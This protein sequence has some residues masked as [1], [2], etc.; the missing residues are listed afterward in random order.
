MCEPRRIEPRRPLIDPAVV[1]GRLTH[2]APFAQGHGAQG[3]FLGLGLLYYTLAYAQRAQV[4]VC[5]G[6]GGGFVPRLMRTAQ[7][8]LALPG[9]RTILVD[10][11]LPEAGFGAPEWLDESCFFRQAFPD[12]EIVLRT[13]ADAAASV[14]TPAGL[15]IDY[16][17][18]DADHSYDGARADFR[19]YLPLLAP[20]GIVTLH[21][22]SQPGCGVHRLIDD[23]RA[24]PR[25]DVLDFPEHGAG[26]ALV[27][28][29]AVAAGRAGRVGRLG[30]SLRRPG[31]A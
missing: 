1:S 16:L 11:N 10:A 22:T 3:G 4:C 13:T 14:F 6:S 8:D 27:R 17:H 19:G 2:E 18:I 28:R 7:H 29:R 21:D 12:V 23:L 24:D 5:L 30:R 31:A 20:A 9:A 25:F 15:V 26:T